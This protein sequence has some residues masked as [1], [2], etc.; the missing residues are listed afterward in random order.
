MNQ[1]GVIKKNT[2]KFLY[3]LVY[4]VLNLMKLFTAVS[5]GTLHYTSNQHA[6]VGFDLGPLLN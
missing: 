6:T 2:Q 5:H 4:K 3:I 1:L